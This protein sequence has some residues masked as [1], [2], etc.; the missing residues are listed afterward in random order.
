M[1]P[2]L[3]RTYLNSD[4]GPVACYE[5]S[6][7]ANE[8]LCLVAGAMGGTKRWPVHRML[9]QR[10]LTTS[11]VRPYP[12]PCASAPTPLVGLNASNLEV[13]SA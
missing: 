6:H 7:S 4:A 3:A 12:P 1:R 2:P 5:W 13:R 10:T 9:T 8:A 11:L